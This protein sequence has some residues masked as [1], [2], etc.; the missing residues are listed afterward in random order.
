MTQW[1]RMT[2]GRGTSTCK[3]P[4]AGVCPRKGK[5]VNVAGGRIVAAEARGR[6]G[7]RG[8]VKRR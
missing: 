5:E 1:G 8:R 3:S 2:R 4:E 6:M 7:V